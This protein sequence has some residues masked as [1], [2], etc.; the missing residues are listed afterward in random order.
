MHEFKIF[1]DRYCKNKLLFSERTGK[2]NIIKKENIS[3]K[4]R[5]GRAL[6]VSGSSKRIISRT[7]YNICDKK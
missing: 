2:S 4:L 7:S 3:V 1:N 5:M 6:S